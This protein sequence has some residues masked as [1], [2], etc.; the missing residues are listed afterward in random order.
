MG[1][2][3]RSAPTRANFSPPGEREWGVTEHSEGVFFAQSGSERVGPFPAEAA[4]REVKRQNEY[5]LIVALAE[6]FLAAEGARELVRIATELRFATAFDRRLAAAIVVLHEREEYDD[7]A[8]TERGPV[9]LV[10][11]FLALLEP[12][13]VVVHEYDSPAD[14]EVNFE[15]LCE[16]R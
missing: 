11:R 9:V 13:G 4:H 10:D 16:E 1:G 8:E 2:T 15:V 3:S 14:A 12:R 5:E 6:A 7:V